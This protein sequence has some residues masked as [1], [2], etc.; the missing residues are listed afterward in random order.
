MLR[1][2]S[3]TSPPAEPPTGPKNRALADRL[4]RLLQ[5]RGLSPRA[6]SKMAGLSADAIRNISTGRAASPR[7]TTLQ[8]LAD[9]LDV[10]LTALTVGFGS[11]E[12]ADIP[13]VP[14][15]PLEPPPF[16]P[17]RLRGGQV[18]ILEYDLRRPVADAAGDIKAGRPF[19]TAW[20][21]P[22]DILEGV[23]AADLAVVRAPG[24]TLA[25]EFLPGDRLLVDVTAFT[26]SPPGV[27]VTWD[28]VGHSL[29]RLAIVGGRENRRVRITTARGTDE[30]AVEDVEV[31]GRVVA[32]L[33]SRV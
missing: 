9:A 1:E 20:S 25:P 2:K 33:W 6:V 24:D 15:R 27:F 14:P 7:V 29:A 28:G 30:L 26:P 8:R 4:A 10:P 17:P 12:V 5:E 31:V 22:N 21:V 3:R 32:K 16:L 13:G 11:E 18:E 23:A 19:S